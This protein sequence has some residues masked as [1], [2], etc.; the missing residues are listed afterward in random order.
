M[1]RLSVQRQAQMQKMHAKHNLRN[2]E[3]RWAEEDYHSNQRWL[4]AQLEVHSIQK[5]VDD[6]VQERT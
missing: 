3:K 2:I 1:H 6:K 4:K 5:R